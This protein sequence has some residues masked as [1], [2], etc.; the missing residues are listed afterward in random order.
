MPKTVHRCRSLCNGDF[1]PSIHRI[2]KRAT[3]VEPTT[4]ELQTSTHGKP[5]SHQVTFQV[6]RIGWSG[7]T[8]SS[9]SLFTQLVLVRRLTH[10]SHLLGCEGQHTNEW[11]FWCNFCLARTVRHPCTPGVRNSAAQILAQH[12]I[13]T[14]ST[15][16]RC[17]IGYAAVNRS[18]FWCAPET[19]I[20]LSQRV[21]WTKM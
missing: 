1:M 3:S 19:A 13:S 20:G 7:R 9:C 15:W 11:E 17:V 6:D 5:C 16:L 8:S 14:A 18:S 21:E 4:R 10:N 12:L 2:G